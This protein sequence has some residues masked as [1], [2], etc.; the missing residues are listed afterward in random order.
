MG[1]VVEAIP[2]QMTGIPGVF[3]AKQLAIHV[4]KHHQAYVDFLNKNVPGGEFAG[5]QLEEILKKASG[6]LFN[7]A[8]QHFNH[9]FFWKC[10]TARAEKPS[11]ALTGFLAKTFGSFDDFKT[12]FIG[13]ASTIFGSG[14]CFLAVNA[15]KSVTINQ[16]SNAAN[17]IKDGGVPLLAVD[18]WEHMWYIDYENRKTEFFGKFWDGVDWSFVEMQAKAAGLL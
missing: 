7:N 18:T 3:S 16:Y 2:Y 9:A 5:K 14:W 6:P 15:D 10:L 11:P 8:A 13:K 12:Q 17:P 1:F 4:T